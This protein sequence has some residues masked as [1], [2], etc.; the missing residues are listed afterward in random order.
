MILQ[1]LSIICGVLAAIL[2][3][4]ALYL[5]FVYAPDD[6]FMGA[7]QRI[8]YFHV[9]SATASYASF[10]VLFA[11]STTYLATR[12]AMAD[13]LAAAAGETGL[14][15]CTIVLASG[16]IWGKAVW[17]VWFN[18]EP[19]LLTFLLLWFLTLAYVLLRS[20]ST[21]SDVA[22]HSAVLGIVAC[23][24]VPLMILSI[25]LLPAV[26]QLH[27]EVIERGGLAAEMKPA[28]FVSML[29]LLVL[30]GLLLTLRARTLLLEQSHNRSVI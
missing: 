4:A 29:A 15:L 23:V 12:S 10:L 9:A 17:G 8:F 7:V 25:K 13:A 11:G 30:Q 22:R 20:F 24:S 26:K 21:A 1:R 18:T 14:L 16:M 28:L 19:R 6:A 27:P 3:P 5:A 2:G